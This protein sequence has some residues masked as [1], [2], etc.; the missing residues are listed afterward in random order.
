MSEEVKLTRYSKGIAVSSTIGIFLSLYGMYVE[1]MAA[2]DDDY[3]AMCD[4]NEKISCTK[5]FT[6][7]YG[8]GFGILGSL[9]GDD[10]ILN[11]P[12]PIFGILFYSTLIGLSEYLIHV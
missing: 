12:N 7:E 4:I 2:Y 11:L 9:V 3:E 1:I 10:S 8:R 6:S 5:V